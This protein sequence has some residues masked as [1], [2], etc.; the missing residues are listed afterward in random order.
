MGIPFS[1]FTSSI[2]WIL[3][4]HSQQRGTSKNWHQVSSD[5]RV[6]YKSHVHLQVHSK[7]YWFSKFASRFFHLPPMPRQ[8]FFFSRYLTSVRAS[9]Q[10]YWSSMNY[11]SVWRFQRVDRYFFSLILGFTQFSMS[12]SLPHGSQSIS[13]FCSSIFDAQKKKETFEH[14]MNYWLAFENMYLLTLASWNNWWL[15]KILFLEVYQSIS[16]QITL[17]IEI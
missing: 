9:V 17:S 15:L 14:L 2:S 3:F 7:S 10:L 1:D 6:S 16:M 11:L 4:V 13:F 8:R 12:Y 5:N